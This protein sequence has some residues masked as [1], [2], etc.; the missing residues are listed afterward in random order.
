MLLVSIYHQGW[1]GADRIRWLTHASKG[2]GSY[3]DNTLVSLTY[4]E[5]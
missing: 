3:S 4:G 1:L 2:S 5:T